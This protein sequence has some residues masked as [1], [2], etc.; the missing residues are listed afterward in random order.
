MLNEI[1]PN[2]LARHVPA[3]KST[4]AETTPCESEDEEDTDD[5]QVSKTQDSKKSPF[6]PSGKAHRLTTPEYVSVL[7]CLANNLPRSKKMNPNA[8]LG[9]GYEVKQ[10]KCHGHFVLCVSPMEGDTLKVSQCTFMCIIIPKPLTFTGDTPDVANKVDRI[11]RS[12][13]Y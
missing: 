8:D 3:S 4:S 11:S 5:T 13:R 6:V 12:W 1:A 7:K 2:V 10:G 9:W